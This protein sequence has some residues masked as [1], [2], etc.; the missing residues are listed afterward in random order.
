MASTVESLAP[1][2]AVIQVVYTGDVAASDMRSTGT[3]VIELARELGIWRFLTDFS[4]ASDLPGGIEMINLISLLEHAGVDADFRQA[5]IW[6]KVAEARL[7]LDFW[8]TMEQNEGL[9]A[10]AFGT[11]EAAL[12]WLEA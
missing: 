5:V 4:E 8:K 12:A 2:H 9:R 10:Q 7:E 1:A 3:S 6:P 11:R